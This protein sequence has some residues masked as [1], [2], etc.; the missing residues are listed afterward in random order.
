VRLEVQSLS[1]HLGEIAGCEAMA[2]A[3]SLAKQLKDTNALALALNWAAALAVNERN[4]AQV[5]CIVSD[6]IELST[7]YNL[8]YFLAVGAIYR[9]W[10]RSASGDTAEGIPWIEQGIRDF[11]ATGAVLSL[12]YYLSLSEDGNYF[13]SFHQ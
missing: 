6:L 2:E 10:A 8:V 9:G 12:S 1:W 4:P 5:E 7:R 13:L 3:I 11:R